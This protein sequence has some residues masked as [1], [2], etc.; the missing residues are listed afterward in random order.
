VFKKGF[1]SGVTS[2]SKICQQIVATSRIVLFR[3]YEIKPPVIL[4]MKKPYPQ[5][6]QI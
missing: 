4:I 6:A 3:E 1:C 5:M 2:V